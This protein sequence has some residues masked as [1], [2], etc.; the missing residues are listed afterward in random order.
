MYRGSVC[1]CRGPSGSA[2]GLTFE[3]SKSARVR[4]QAARAPCR[5]AL[6]IV[7]KTRE[8][9]AK[10]LVFAA[11]QTAC[12]REKLDQRSTSCSECQAESSRRGIRAALMHCVTV[13]RTGG[14]ES[15]RRFR[16]DVEARNTETSI[17]SWSIRPMVLLLGAGVRATHHVVAVSGHGANRSGPFSSNALKI[18][19]VREFASRGR[20]NSP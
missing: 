4:E 1:Q 11:L 12:A 10:P 7:S 14:V 8:V 9:D 17:N 16:M 20:R 18:R 15:T 6:T 13:L 2:G 19:K 3:N 5:P